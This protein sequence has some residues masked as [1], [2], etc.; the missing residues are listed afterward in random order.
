MPLKD[1]MFVIFTTAARHVALGVPAKSFLDQT[2]ASLWSKG[3]DHLTRD[4]AY[5]EVRNARLAAG[6]PTGSLDEEEISVLA[7]VSEEK[8]KALNF[9]Y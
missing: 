4:S 5:K 1:E 7:D 8:F 2:A 6:D 3:V 9:T